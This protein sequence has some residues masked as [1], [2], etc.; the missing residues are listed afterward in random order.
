M[1]QSMGR[2]VLH[3]AAMA[4]AL[5]A[6]AETAGAMTLREA[7]ETALS[8]NPGM[9]AAMAGVEAAGSAAD[10][11][12]G[13]MGPEVDLAE[14]YSRTTNPMYAFGSLLNQERIGQRDFEPARL[15]DPDPI[16]NYRTSLELR[17]P[18]FAGG[19]I[20]NEY[21][22][23]RAGERIKRSDLALAGR[24]V[25]MAVIETWLDLRLLDERRAVL[26]KSLK[27]AAESARAVADRVEAGMALETALLD[28]KINE[29]RTRRELNETIAA[30][31]TAL[32]ALR[33]LLGAPDDPGIEPVFGEYRPSVAPGTLAELKAKGL[34]T[35]PEILKARDEVERAR[36]D[37]ASARGGF[38][39][40][41][42]LAAD[43]SWNQETLGSGG[44]ESWQVGVVARI[45]LFRGGRNKA[46]VRAARARLDA[47][48]YM[49]TE[50]ENGVRLEIEKAHRRLAT[51]RRNLDISRE[52]VALARE[53]HR[54]NRQR[55]T[56]GMNTAT[57]LLNSETQLKKAAL[58]LNSAER[59]LLLAMAA[60]DLA[61]G[62]DGLFYEVNDK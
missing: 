2:T 38:L 62:G 58:G 27:L 43:Y 18:I 32:T 36:A 11:A 19:R 3:V 56:Q 47:A 29:Q 6:A 14:S 26:E 39:P 52:E 17:Q 46:A 35:R 41:V 28:A 54:M 5:A 23:A 48:G 50:V 57:D 61:I 9:K 12:R 44:G 13:A 10:V 33:S 45:S 31:A 42:G 59:G 22:K 8:S 53:S 7:V 20:E 37:L 30:R 21:K 60:L 25:T 40:E 1:R 15:N 16:D 24:R 51:A 4:V 34:A 49:K 55:Y